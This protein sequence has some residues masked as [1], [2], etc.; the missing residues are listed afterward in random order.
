MLVMLLVAHWCMAQNTLTALIQDVHSKKPMVGV[1]LQIKALNKGG[2]SNEAGIVILQNIPSGKYL[3]NAS[4]IG[5][6]D[7]ER[8]VQF[9]YNDTL[10]ILMNEEDG[11]DEMDDH[12]DHELD[13]IIV[14]STRIARSNLRVPTRVEFIAGEELQEKGN[15]KPGDIRMLLNESTGIQ[16]QQVSATSA[17]ASIR[18]QGLDGRYTQLLRDGLPLYAGF[19]GGLGLLQTPPLDLQQ[20]EIIKGA[21]STLY[22]GGAIAGLVNLI[23]KEPEYR[24]ETN[25]MVNAT[26]AGGWDI[27]GFHSHRAKHTGV[28]VFASRNTT[29]AYDPANLGLSAI[30]K[31]SRYVFNP[32]LFVY[33][34]ANTTIDLG[35][36]LTF[37]DR[38]GGDMEYIKGRGNTVRS[39]FEKN[40]SN[41]VT[42]QFR[43]THQFKDYSS[44]TVKHSLSHFK[45]EISIPQYVFDGKQLSSYTE[46]AYHHL[47][48]GSDWVAGINLYTD[49]FK[50]YPKDA[51]PRRNYT[52]QTFGVFVQNTLDVTN[53]LQLETGLRGDHNSMGKFAFLPRIAALFNISPAFSSRLGGGLG[54]KMPTLFTEETEMLNYQQVLPLGNAADRLERSYGANFDINYRGK[55]FDELQINVNQ[56]FFYTRINY[57]LMLGTLS[58]GMHELRNTAGYIDTKGWETNVKLAYDDLKLFIGYTYTDANVNASNTRYTNYLTA[59]HRLNNVLMYEKEGKWKAG[60]EAYYFSNQALRDGTTGKSYWILGFMAE[61]LWK[62]FSLFVNFENFTDT[63]QT[64]FGAIHSGT[65]TNPVFRDIYAP[66]D[67]FVVNGGLKLRL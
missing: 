66:L 50:E 28:T 7:L 30:P 27:S 42:T 55:L 37:E 53:W 36:N 12:D 40:N 67:G 26:S 23:S 21:A 34:G 51:F 32:K 33:A 44:L 17:N 60:L 15:M 16:T 10:V 11:E 61:K 19:S 20:V 65:I 62:Q 64:R 1:S 35:V 4:H 9:P 8:T 63:R 14:N 5:Y 48:E 41:R 47:R 52:Q 25:F 6:K 43:L 24:P 29:K 58:S 54:Y 45:R 13:E 2:V 18:I 49:A 59:R 38:L 22:G 31:T 46:V 39:Y 3:V 57:P 56:L